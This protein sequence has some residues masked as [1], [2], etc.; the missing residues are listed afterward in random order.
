MTHGRIIASIWWL[1]FKLCIVWFLV[2]SDVPQF[3]YQNF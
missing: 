3:T 1:L 2:R